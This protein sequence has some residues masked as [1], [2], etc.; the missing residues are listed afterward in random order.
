M[1]KSLNSA[2]EIP[3]SKPNA[4]EL[5]QQLKMTVPAIKR[6]HTKALKLGIEIPE[7]STYRQAEELI[8]NKEMDDDPEDGKPPTKQQ[9]NKITKLGG[10]PTSVTNRWRAEEYISD[11]EDKRVNEKDEKEQWV[12][13]IL[14][15]Y[16]DPNDDFKT[17]DMKKPSKALLR[18]VYDYAKAQG[19]EAEWE[20][21]PSTFERVIL[22]IAASRL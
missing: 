12:E 16:F 3:L 19:F 21:D 13:Y 6:Q 17:F 11:L 14:E 8:S 1:I 10:I 15:W 9:L 5:I 18:K 20:S 2:A 22:S 7:G 4:S